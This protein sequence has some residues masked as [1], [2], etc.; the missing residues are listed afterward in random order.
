MQAVFYK[1]LT[2]LG[3]A[4]LVSVSMSVSF[5]ISGA[6]AEP[7]LLNAEK[8]AKS[9]KSDKPEPDASITLTLEKQAEI[10]NQAAKV[11]DKPLTTRLNALHND[12]T[13]QDR[14]IYNE[15]RDDEE[16][17]TADIGMLWEVAVERSGTI[18]YAIEKLSKKDATGQPVQGQAF[19]KKLLNNLIH[20]GGVA[21]TMWTGT[22]A[23]LI[24]SNLVQSV[25]RDDDA[26]TQLTR[27]TD[28]D[29]VI[30]AKEVEALQSDIIE[31]Y[32]HYRHAKTQLQISNDAILMADRQYKAVNSQ[33]KPG[34]K[35]ASADQQSVLTL[36]DTVY[37]NLKQTRHQAKADYNQAKSELALL[38]G[39]AA[40]AA[41]E[42]QID[43][44]T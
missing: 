11:L 30:L 40:V 5:S 19:S 24:G 32:Y 44:A 42:K 31:R 13:F 36:I 34:K 14:A 2:A 16:L 21:G 27:V 39:N 37:D 18:R 3:L 1:P 25:V 10:N 9:Q 33:K 17:A 6:V 7:T 20:L 41:L 12:V 26:N 15:L 8:S 23:G 38:V 29:M 22:P 28:A 4:L 35:T 43:P